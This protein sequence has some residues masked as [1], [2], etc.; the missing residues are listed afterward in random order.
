M[1]DQLSFDFDHAHG[2]VSGIALWREMRAAQLEALARR[3][4]LPI[5]H[6]VRVWL[7]SGVMIEGSLALAS[8]ELWTDPHRSQE[9]PLR[10]GKVDF[11]AAEV[12]SCVRID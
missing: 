10:I 7:A 12:E 8:D 3:N 5:G 4:G 6:P 9:L 1:S 11:R 2:A